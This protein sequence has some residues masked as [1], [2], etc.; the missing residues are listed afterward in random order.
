VLSWFVNP[1]EHAAAG[2]TKTLRLSTGYKTLYSKETDE[3]DMQMR[4][5][6]RRTVDLMVKL[7]VNGYGRSSGKRWMRGRRGSL[8]VL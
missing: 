5:T 1:V 4:S 8:L 2:A 6:R 7:L 3:Y